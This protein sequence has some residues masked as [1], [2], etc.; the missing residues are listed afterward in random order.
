MKPLSLFLLLCLIQPVYA[1]QAPVQSLE[2]ALQTAY[3][4]QNYP[5]ALE[6]S[7]L[8]LAAT[9]TEASLHY[10]TGTLA[11]LSGN[12]ML[13]SSHLQKALELEPDRVEY[14]N[15]LGLAWFAQGD[16]DAARALYQETLRR[17]PLAQ[18]LRINLGELEARTGHL[19]AARTAWKQA[20][21]Q[22]FKP[23]LEKRLQI[24]PPAPRPVFS[25][26]AALAAYR[27]AVSQE[28]TGATQQALH[29]LNQILH[30]FPDCTAARYRRARLLSALGNQQAARQDLERLLADNPQH[31]AA[32]LERARMAL[33]EKKYAAAE[34]DLWE[35]LY[36]NPGQDGARLLLLDVLSAQK[37]YAAQVQLL[38]DW[39]KVWPED[40][41]NRLRLVE[42]W[43]AQ[44]KTQQALE[45]LL[46][47]AKFGQASSDSLFTLAQLY[48]RLG[49]PDLAQP[50]F[51]QALKQGDPPVTAQADTA[52]WLATQ[53]QA[54][55][56]LQILRTYL[57]SHPQDYQALILAAQLALQFNQSQAAVTWLAQARQTPQ[58]APDVDKYLAL[59]WIQQG[60]HQEAR[61][62]LL[63]YLH[64]YPHTSDR[65]ILTELLNLLKS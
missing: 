49:Q 36:L 11:L 30:N 31:V 5:R 27:Q 64:Q 16:T 54:S 3:A 2:E 50:W 59:A 40:E 7:L 4:E 51:E 63:H 24:L 46:P 26:A 15:H 35:V 9:P 8:Q 23:T 42:I 53:N 14:I 25:P 1:L 47:L 41:K 33:I 60:K 21:Q 58:P 37:K 62:V 10:R 44:G 52:A 55:K 43:S 61:Q 12:P 17:R 39:L 19:E 6:L 65:R 18:A 34:A 29:T 13:A 56:A 32:R 28:E 45:L 48:W 57:Q 38:E 22:R 20:Q